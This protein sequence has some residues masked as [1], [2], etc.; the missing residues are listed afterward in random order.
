MTNQQFSLNLTALRKEMANARLDGFI[1]PRTDEYQSEYLSPSEERVAFMTGF[2]G[3][4]AT[5]IVMKDGAAFFTDGRYTL[6]AAKQVPK[7]YFDIYD[8]AVKTPIAW[9]KEN[10]GKKI[11]IGF[12]PWM[13]SAENAK[14]LKETLAGAGGEAVPVDRNLVDKIWKDRPER[15]A[16]P[17]TH[18]DTVYAGKASAEKR[19]EIAAELRKKGVAAAIISDA[20]SVAWLLN[21]R[22]HDVRCTPLPLSRA[23]LHADGS[24][25]WFVDERKVSES[26][27]AILGSGCT[28]STPEKFEKSLTELAR[29]QRPVLVDFS[30]TPQAILDILEHAR[31]GVER[32]EDPCLMLR[33]VKNNVEL[34]G[35]KAASQRDS[36]AVVNFLA[37]LDAHWERDGVDELTA[38]RKLEEFRRVDALFQEPSF[39]TISAA[40]EHGAVIHYRATDASNAKLVRGQLYLV[41]SGGQYIDGTTDVTRTV[42]LGNPSVEMR[43]NFTRV[44]K[45]HI[46]L[47]SVRFPEDTTGAELDSFARQYLWAKGLDYAHGTGHGVGCYLEVHESPVGISKRNKTPL[48]P[49]MVLS[50]EPG[51]YR[52]GHYGIRIESLMAV[53]EF[54][55]GELKTMGFEMLT[56]VPIDKRLIDLS[57][58][59]DAEIAWVNAYHK[60]VREALSPMV[61]NAL[62][63]EAATESIEKRP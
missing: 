39:E 1:V 8:V 19:Q 56:L 6:Q 61:D 2:T 14:C 63:L 13:H 51:Y 42:T 60:K 37:W 55:G 26:L 48:K 59:T 3:S 30:R 35:M 52:E 20:A 62:W 29:T 17:V 54:V 46:A 53:T 31:V 50:N 5:L 47:A 44:L 22:G 38:E 33:A 11:R 23:I 45:G 27:K 40:G 25:E 10:A 24:V 7:D 58:L 28:V 12:D 57:L 18:L 4:A 21:V 49:N 41:D 32:G 15:P 16:E 9:L 34:T 36:A 43:Q